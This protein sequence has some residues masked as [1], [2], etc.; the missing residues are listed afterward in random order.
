[1]AP[2]PAH[3]MDAYSLQMRNLHRRYNLSKGALQLFTALDEHRNGP[4]DPDALARMLRM[5]PHMR[6]AC[7]DTISSLAEAMQKQPTPDCIRECTELITCC[8][9]ML[10]LAN[11]PKKE[12]SFPIMRLPLELRQRV[13]KFYFRGLF[14]KA[15]PDPV[16]IIP[17]RKSICPCPPHENQRTDRARQLDM[18]L[19]RVSKPIRDEALQAWFEAQDFDFACCC[20]LNDHLLKNLNLRNNIRRV[21]VHWTGPIPDV[22]FRRLKE[23][24]NLKVL[25]ILIS[26]STTKACLSVSYISS[27]QPVGWLPEREETLALFFNFK[28][29]T[30]LCDAKGIEELLELRGLEQVAVEHVDKS[31]AWLRTNEERHGLQLLLEDHITQ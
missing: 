28:A 16:V 2:R 26:K 23:V 7:T 18:P 25:T 20:Q 19:C 9:D 27:R 5:S 10:A 24:P 14:T 11:Q 4:K 29:S 13:Y 8:T 17:Y 1:M 31:Q 12:D 21:K 15:R 3:R 6:Q 30:R 22:A